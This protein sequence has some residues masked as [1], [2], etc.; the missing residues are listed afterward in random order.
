MEH[1][2]GRGS[3][4]RLKHIALPPAD[5]LALLLRAHRI[6]FAREVVFAP[7]RKFRADFKIGRVLV[8]VEGGVWLV[9]GGGHQRG[10]GFTKDVYKYELARSLGYQVVRVI[11]EAIDSGECIAWIKKALEAK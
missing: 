9:G 7:P 6:P 2:S 4:I 3:V 11:P 10:K 1:G 5:R 8:E